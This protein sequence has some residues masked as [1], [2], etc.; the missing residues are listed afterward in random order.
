MMK[1]LQSEAIFSYRIFAF[2]LLACPDS[3]AAGW[4]LL[5]A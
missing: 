1:N 2:A 3:I 4:L 5:L